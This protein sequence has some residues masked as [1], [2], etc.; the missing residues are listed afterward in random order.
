MKKYVAA[1]CLLAFAG[2]SHAQDPNDLL[3]LGEDQIE[4]YSEAQIE[5]GQNNIEATE[6]AISGINDALG[7][8]NT[9]M[10]IYNNAQD[11]Y[12]ASQA[13]SNGECA[14]DFS[15]SSGAM[16]PTHCPTA[17]CQDCY[18]RAV[19]ELNFIRRQL[20]R[21][22]CIYNNTKNFTN[23]AIAFGDNASGI[24]AVTGLAWQSARG[25]IV[26]AMNHMKQTYDSKYTGMMGTLERSLHAISQCEESFGEHDWYQRFGFIYF[27]FM[28]DK[29]KRAD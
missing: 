11:L 13:L 20:G 17:D 6:N 25:E 18:T 16:M 8:M 1:I 3:N 10:N 28:Q 21:L 23:S 7:H 19:N 4:Q 2:I 22:S 24:H 9:V 5:Q 12:N 15:T 14:P 29:Y 27:E 26:A